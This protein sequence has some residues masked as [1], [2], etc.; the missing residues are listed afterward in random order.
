[1]PKTKYKKKIKNGNEY[2]FYRFRHKN[3]PKAKDLYGKTVGELDKKI[4]AL[5]YELDRGV[6]SEKA[7][8][9][10]YME[11]WINSTYVLG[12]KDSTV[13]NYKSKFKKYILGYPVS[14]IR[15]C[16]LTA[17]DVQQH[18][19]NMVED[20]AS[21]IVVKKVHEL[22]APCI[23]Y[24]FTQGK[25]VMDFSRSLKIPEIECHK[26]ENTRK[27]GRALTVEEQKKL[28]SMVKGS[29]YELLIK[30][31]LFTGLREGEALALEWTDINFEDKSISITKSLSYKADQ[32]TGK[33]CFKVT[34]PKTKNSIRKVP[35]PDFLAKELAEYRKKYVERK[36]LLA[37]LFEDRNVVFCTEKG[38][39]ITSS[40]LIVYIKKISD[41]MKGKRFNVH[42]L[43]H[44]YVTRLF[45]YGENPKKVQALVGHS[46]IKTTMDI[47]THVT[48]EEK[49]KS[50]SSLDMLHSE[51]G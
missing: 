3:L 13:A 33:H 44:T 9:G 47:Y 20:G 43:R 8:F 12:K 6:T 39:Y 18:Y 46:S 30:V 48:D 28:L 25:I 5:K 4:E 21:K 45:E 34:E 49:R 16:D 38:N 10:D 19:K 23:R 42:D 11:K 31:F 40:Q 14:S 24:A 29:R 7:C 26:A 27:T 2:F 51:I 32:N 37:N 15:M 50:V 17:L 22:I 35:I 41:E 36:L 1:M